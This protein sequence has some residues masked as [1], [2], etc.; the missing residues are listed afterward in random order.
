M[1]RYRDTRP[2]KYQLLE[3]Y[4]LYVGVHPAYSPVY[5]DFLQL[6]M[7]GI[8]KIRA[9]YSW[10]GPSG[11]AIDT[12]SFMR[13]SLVHDALYQMIRLG[14]LPADRKSRADDVL[15]RI[16]LED[17]M[18]RVRAEWVHLALSLFG[19][20]RT[21]PLPEDRGRVMEAP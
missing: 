20:R 6:D 14:L 5:T 2:Y 1:I 11:P 9:G 18:S 4:D 12:K 17:G 16:C 13:G 8:L 21:K 19:S 3:T 10:D 15:K 7:N